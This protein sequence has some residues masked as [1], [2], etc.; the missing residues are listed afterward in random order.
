MF[1]DLFHFLS[2]GGEEVG[3][4]FQFRAFTHT[5]FVSVDFRN[6][7]FQLERVG[8]LVD[9]QAYHYNK[10]N[11]DISENTGFKHIN[12]IIGLC[13]YILRELISYIR[14]EKPIHRRANTECAVG[15]YPN[16]KQHDERFPER[17]TEYTSD[18]ERK[19]DGRRDVHDSDIE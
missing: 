1:H 19:N 15:Y 17:D 12:T 8:F 2:H 7:T 18:D 9:F 6:D 14:K 3:R 4:E 13:I 5:V 11:N 16:N 10:N